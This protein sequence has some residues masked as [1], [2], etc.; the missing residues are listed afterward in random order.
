MIHDTVTL[1]HGA[2]GKQTS[3]LIEKVFRAHFENPLFTPDDAAVLE[4]PAGRLAMSARYAA[5]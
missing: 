4:I 3:E 1:A 5:K 2:G